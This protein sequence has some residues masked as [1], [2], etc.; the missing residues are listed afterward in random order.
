MQNLVICHP[1][2]GGDGV[3][4]SCD[5]PPP[6]DPAGWA[7][8]DRSDRFLSWV[9]AVPSRVVRLANK[10]PGAK[11]LR[12]VRN[13]AGSRTARRPELSS[14]PGAIE[15]SSRRMQ[16]QDVSPCSLGPVLRQ[17]L[18]EGP[19]LRRA[20]QS[21]YPLAPPY[22]WQT[23]LPGATAPEVPPGSCRSVSE[24]SKKAGLRLMLNIAVLFL[25]FSASCGRISCAALQPR[26]GHS[27]FFL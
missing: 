21:P 11:F 4:D 6:G 10:Y 22:S 27:A 20:R 9:Q 15:P 12:L 1:W 16:Q 25:S 13:T 3:H 8:S 7:A 26:S 2:V 24:V 5:D 18:H 14:I 23:T 19:S 17:S